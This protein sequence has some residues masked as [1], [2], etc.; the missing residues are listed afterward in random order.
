MSMYTRSSCNPSL[1]RSPLPILLAQLLTQ[2]ASPK[3]VPSQPLPTDAR[4][5][6]LTQSKGDILQL[7]CSVAPAPAAKKSAVPR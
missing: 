7:L 2:Q 1:K 5:T 6:D 4:M 3:I